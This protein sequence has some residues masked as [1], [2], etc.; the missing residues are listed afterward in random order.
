MFHA[1]FQAPT[2][3]VTVFRLILSEQEKLV[4]QPHVAKA[5]PR[6]VQSVLGV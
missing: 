2:T 6:L 1:I 5:N 4:E 3:S